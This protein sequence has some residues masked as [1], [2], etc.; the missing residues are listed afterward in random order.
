MHMV[1]TQTISPRLR[2]FNDQLINSTH[3]LLADWLATN[4]PIQAIMPCNNYSS[5]CQ[6]Y[7]AIVS[8]CITE[9]IQWRKMFWDGGGGGAD[10]RW[11][12][13]TM[14]PTQSRGSNLKFECWCNL[15]PNIPPL[16]IK[17]SYSKIKSR[18]HNSC[19]NI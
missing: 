11:L 14:K 7:F 6:Y 12:G 8:T 16:V 2:S 3:F 10:M 13:Y 5:L 17:L 19:A 4:S 15:S 9:G 1:W 18:V